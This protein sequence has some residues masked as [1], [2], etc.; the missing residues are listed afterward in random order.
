MTRVVKGINYAK[1]CDRPKGIPQSRPRGSTAKAQGLR[2]ER[3]VGKALGPLVL[4]GQWFEYEDSFGPG[5]CQTDFLLLCR[6]YCCVI[7]SKYTWVAEGHFQVECLYLP[8]VEE[9][10]KRPTFGFVV[11]KRLTNEIKRANVEVTTDLAVA[12]DGAARGKRMVLH[13]IG[14]G[15]LALPR[16]Y[17]P[18]MP[19]LKRVA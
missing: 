9:V 14:V 12:I 1:C 8:V 18:R 5:V 4:E 13:W 7:E 3:P 11:C 19:S 2:Y 15:S 17:D 6:D 10:W 16:A